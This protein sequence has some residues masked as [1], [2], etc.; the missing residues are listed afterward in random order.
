M[1]YSANIKLKHG[2]IAK[3]Q[4]KPRSARLCWVVLSRSQ[5]SILQIYPTILFWVL[6]KILW[7][8]PKQGRDLK[9]FAFHVFKE[10]SLCQRNS[11]LKFL[12]KSFL[13]TGHITHQLRSRF[14]CFLLIWAV[15]FIGKIQIS[16]AKTSEVF[17]RVS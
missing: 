9:L 8:C 4:T 1:I 14:S 13:N 2:F 3:K 12:V 17:K 10:Q 5:T 7:L 15:Y 11:G 16:F 6:S